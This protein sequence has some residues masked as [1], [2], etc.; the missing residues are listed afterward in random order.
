MGS[1]NTNGR[2]VLI[3]ENAQLPGCYWNG[4]IDDVRIYGYALSEAEIKAVDAGHGPGPT[5]N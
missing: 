1:I 4:P 5:E 2:E 3:G